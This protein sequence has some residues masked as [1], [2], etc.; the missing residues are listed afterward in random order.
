MR[1]RSTSQCGVHVFPYV[2]VLN[3]YVVVVSL[4]SPELA[5]SI[6]YLQHPWCGLGDSDDRSESFQL[7]SCYCVRTVG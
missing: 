6:H 2:F 1:L 5:K 3:R 4:H 7:T